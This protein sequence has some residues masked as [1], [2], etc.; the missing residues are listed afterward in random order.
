M[1]NSYTYDL[2]NQLTRL[3]SQAGAF[4]F[5]YDDL[6][7]MTKMT[8]PNGMKTEMSFEGDMRISKVEHFKKGA[9][10]DKA[11]SLFSYQYDYNDNKKRMKTFRGTLPVNETLNYTYDKK[12]SF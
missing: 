3:N 9:L 8:Y 10:F 5:E 2:E 7:R 11:Q 12:D 1:E 4:N 6:S